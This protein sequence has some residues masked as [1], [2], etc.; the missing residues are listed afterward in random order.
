MNAFPTPTFP[1][2][3]DAALPR[4]PH[5]G[6][7]ASAPCTCVACPQQRAAGQTAMQAGA[8]PAAL[9]HCAACNCA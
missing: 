1:S 7:G 5:C 3:N 2:A 8:T 4:Q 9:C 6:T